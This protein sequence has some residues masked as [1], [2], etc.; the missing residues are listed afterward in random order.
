MMVATMGVGVAG[1]IPASA[2]G[3]I[4]TT[5]D[6]VEEGPVVSEETVQAS[7]PADGSYAVT[8]DG[9]I[10]VAP[11]VYVNVPGH[12]GAQN[13]ATDTEA[14]SGIDAV[15]PVE[16]Y[17]T[18]DE[19]AP[20]PAEALE[21]S[22]LDTTAT[23]ATTPWAACGAYDSKT[24]LVK[25]YSRQAISGVSGRTAHL[26]CGTQTYWGYRH[27]KYR[28]A[29][30]WQ[31]KAAL[32]GGEWRSFTDWALRNTFT[33]PCLKYRQ[34]SNDTLQYVK[35]IY[36]KDRYGRV[37]NKFAARASVARVTQNIITAYP[38]PPLSST[39]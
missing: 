19:N 29:S 14:G 31:A 20:V 15:A 4:A 16:G 8:S 11:E 18:V 32:V 10:Y 12:G 24:K 27:I 37:I 3:R 17:T 25:D 35:N 21:G 34:T 22:S 7:V 13:L 6:P 38:Q 2:G 23:A 33:Y 5:I 30:N 39:C 9:D 26:K 36:L 1:Q 28:H